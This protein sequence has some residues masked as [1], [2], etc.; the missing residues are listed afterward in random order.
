[1]CG[2]NGIIKFNQE[3]VY[4]EELKRMNDKIKHRGPDD[5]GIFI[6]KN[7]GL[8]HNRLSILDLSQNGHQ[9]M[10]KNHQ[11]KKAI[12]TYNGEI[13]NFQ[14]IRSE[15]QQ[16]GYQF[17][18]DTDTEVILASYLEYGP[19]CVT[20]FNGMFAFVI[21]DPIKQ[22]IFAARDR[23]GKKPFKY[24]LDHNQFIFSS[25]LKAILLNKEIKRE[26]DWSAIDDYLTLNYIPNPH[27]GFK[28]ICKLPHAHYFIL[29]LNTKNIEF[30]KYFDLDYSPRFNL[31]EKEWL[32]LI[33]S[34]LEEAVKKRLIAD[35][36]LGAFL[37]GGLDSSAIVMMMSRH[38]SKVKTFSIVFEENDF[39]ESAY[40][41][42][43][44]KIFK[45]EHT[46]FKVNSNDL[47]QHITTLVK[48]YEEPF[49]D[50]S[51]LPTF[52]LSKITKPH[53]TVVLSGDG[54]D[55]NFG[56][57]TRYPKTIAIRRHPLILIAYKFCTSA[58]RKNFSTLRKLKVIN[59]NTATWHYNFTCCFDT[60][61]KDQIYQPDFIKN[62]LNKKSNLYEQIL[63]N[64]NL[65]EADQMF[66]LDF[67]SYIPD[68]INVK[69]DMASMHHALEV[70]SP[71]LDYEFISLT[72]QIPW[73]LKIDYLQSKKI[74]KKML[75]QYLPQEII[76]RKK[77][78]FGVP[79]HHWFKNELKEYTTDIILN[80][81]G[82]ASQIIKK[83]AL[84]KLLR[85]HFLID[86]QDNSIKLWILMNLNLWYSSYFN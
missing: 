77:Q 27:T 81:N 44:A 67:N 80:K 50:S 7:I 75:K 17:F 33:E 84:E 11:N 34:K 25:E 48:H 47:P 61:L 55:E 69:V 32:P 65:S 57:Y 14:N 2:I 74:F 42:Q 63:A 5:T 24:Y 37:S 72:A 16:K 54:G 4:P 78:G 52:I 83:E 76:Y 28:N 13:Y 19:N 49:A 40:A 86:K 60:P 26:V 68:D 22:I 15:L 73:R 38:L 71:M 39:D 59:K 82:L 85:D 58:I 8:G 51:Q 46:E 45:T 64:K 62:H 35:V 9:P 31:T 29:D 79:L 53:A 30:K 21:Y 10:I 3:P 41:R 43:I 1:M 66:Y 12:I 23:L 36:P 56:G 18:S 20:K 6:D 70:R